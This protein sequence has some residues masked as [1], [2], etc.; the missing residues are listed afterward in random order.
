M[1][2]CFTV[3]EHF[4]SD[5]TWRHLLLLIE[6]EQQLQASM[7]FCSKDRHAL[8]SKCSVFVPVFHNA[9]ETFL[10]LGLWRSKQIFPGLTSYR[11][12]LQ[13]RLNPALFWTLLPLSFCTPRT[14]PPGWDACL[15]PAPAPSQ[16]LVLYSWQFIAWHL[17]FFL[18]YLLR[19]WKCNRTVHWQ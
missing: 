16:L 15:G 8:S 12:D 2:I 1:K 7:P 19:W 10:S 9:C 4:F 14:A 17:D 13:K 18:N 6:N 3:L 5:V 11:Q